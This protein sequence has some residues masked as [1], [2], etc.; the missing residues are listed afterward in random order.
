MNGTVNPGQSTRAA[1]ADL[2]V[3][4]DTVNQARRSGVSNLTPETVTGRRSNVSAE[5]V[6]TGEARDLKHVA[7]MLRRAEV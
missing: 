7:Y 3:S 2:G 6:P 5:R 1:S 4:H